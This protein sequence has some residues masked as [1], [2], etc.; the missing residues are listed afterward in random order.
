M[1]GFVWGRGEAGG[2]GEGR[3]PFPPPTIDKTLVLKV[4]VEAGKIGAITK[5]CDKN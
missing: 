3:I 4:M 2:F 5:F 1:S